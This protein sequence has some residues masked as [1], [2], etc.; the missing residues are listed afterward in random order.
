MNPPTLDSSAPTPPPPP[1]PIAAASATIPP[2]VGG[3]KV[4]SVRK[5]FP[6]KPVL[7]LL[8]ILVLIVVGVVVGK[9]LLARK[10]SGTANLT[11]WGLWESK[12]V[13]QPLIDEYEAAHPGVK[14][15]YIFQSPREYRER[16]QNTLSSGSGPDIFR[17]HNSWVPMF[18]ADLA[19]IPANVYSAA[20]FETTFYPTVKQDLR[21]GNNYVAIPLEFDGLAM[22]VNQDLLTKGGQTVPTSWE[23]L[24]KAAIALSVCDSEDGKCTPGSR[25]LVSGAAM[26]TADNIDHWQDI[27]SLLMLQNNVNLNSP[28]GQSAE[29]A[30]Q[31]YTIFNRSDHIWDSTLPNSVQAFAQGKVAII[32]AP[33]WRVFDIKTSAPQLNFNIY[34]VPQLPLDPAR[35]EKPV[36]W[37]SYWAEAVNKKSPSSA[38]AWDF[39]KFLSSQESLQKL[40]K[41]ATT[42]GRDFGEPYSR[43]D[44]ANL[45]IAAPKVSAYINQAPQAKSWYIASST[46]DG[47]TG[48]NSKL[49][50]YFADA[51]NGVNQG[52]TPTESVK[53][54]NSGINQ[55]LSAY[56]LVS[57]LAPAQ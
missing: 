17:I 50:A 55:V 41:N 3:A 37:A 53:T 13:I 1:S 32:F 56:G 5:S 36:T 47:A 44:M 30:L 16:L 49:S 26:G 6:I 9:Q 20:D 23:D 27:V 29:E 52:R 28:L 15:D 19:T 21:I 7:V 25:I 2:S 48:I 34:A 57:P 54:L 14:I 8:V 42:A 18:K 45:L 39:I 46:F 11:Y 22:Y 40:Y 38:V 10:S 33:S 24:R 4:K 35:G 43:V 12:D 31:Y 51:I